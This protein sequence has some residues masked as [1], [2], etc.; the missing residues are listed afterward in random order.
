MSTSHL[1]LKL[2]E[3]QENGYWALLAN[4]ALSCKDL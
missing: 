1:E 3:K 4:D 2:E